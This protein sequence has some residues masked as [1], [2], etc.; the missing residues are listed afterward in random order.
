MNTKSTELDQ[1]FSYKND[2]Q[3]TRYHRA[4]LALSLGIAIGCIALAFCGIL[5]GD[6]I[7]QFFQGVY[8]A[9]VL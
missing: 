1:D 4:D 3:I 8:K 7:D 5:Y 6:K 9:L 2:P